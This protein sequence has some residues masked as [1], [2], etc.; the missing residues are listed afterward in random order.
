MERVLIRKVHPD[1]TRRYAGAVAAVSS[2]TPDGAC[3]ADGRPAQGLVHEVQGVTAW[4]GAQR[5]EALLN[6]VMS[7]RAFEREF[8]LVELG[9]ASI[10][11][12]YGVP[13]Y[14]VNP[15]DYEPI[16]RDLAALVAAGYL[17]EMGNGWYRSLR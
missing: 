5:L 2:L 9:N 10:C 8:K 14:S 16:V 1:R 12:R 13:Q 7:P 15:A 17:E 3:L 4:Q 6:L 11:T